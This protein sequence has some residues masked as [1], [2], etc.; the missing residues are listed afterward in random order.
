MVILDTQECSTLLYYINTNWTVIKNSPEHYNKYVE[1][2][3][4]EKLE[5]GHRVIF[6]F[7]DYKFLKKLT[8]L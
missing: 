5:I 3:F 1:G 6:T 2:N 8:K 4:E 7:E